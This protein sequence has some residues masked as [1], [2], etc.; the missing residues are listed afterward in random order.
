M[1]RDLSG[2]RQENPFAA[3]G[4]ARIRL[5]VDRS[6]TTEGREL[7]RES[8]VRFSRFLRLHSECFL[9]VLCALCGEIFVGHLESDSPRRSVYIVNKAGQSN[10]RI[11]ATLPGGAVMKN[12]RVIHVALAIGILL[13]SRPVVA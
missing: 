11:S 2:N 4:Q 6:F 3:A 1:Q 8:N 13:F 5:G 12:P 7:G 9:C 10:R